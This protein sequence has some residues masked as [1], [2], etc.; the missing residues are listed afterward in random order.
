ML[1]KFVL[2]DFALLITAWQP[3][4]VWKSMLI[5]PLI[6]RVLKM[7]HKDVFLLSRERSWVF[8]FV[9]KITASL[10]TLLLIAIMVK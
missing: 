3:Q 10:I 6:E 9:L 4:G 8:Y 2:T 1:L 5:Q 7:T